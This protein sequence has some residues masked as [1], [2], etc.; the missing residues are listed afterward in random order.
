[1]C[2]NGTF[3]GIVRVA[4]SVGCSALLTAVAT[5][6]QTQSDW[7]KIGSPAVELSL[8]AAATGPVAQVWFSPDGTQLFARTA[9]GRTFIT[10]DFESWSAVSD[11]VPPAPAPAPAV[12]LP[13]PG[14]AVMIALTDPSQLFALGQQLFRSEDG[15]RSWVDL[16]KNRS[17]SVVGTGQHSIAVSPADADQLVLAND[18]GVWRSLDGGLTWA[19]LNQALPNLSIRRILATPN[20]AH[21]VQVEADSLGS[22]ELPPGTSLWLAASNASHTQETALLARYSG[23]IGTAITA[24]AAAGAIV[25]AGSRDGRIWVS[26]DGGATFRISR[27]ETAGPVERFYVDPTEPTLA[28]AALSGSGPHVLRTTTT[29]SLWDDLTGN[30]P[31]APAHGITAERA[32]GAVYVATDQGVFL[33]RTDLQNATVPAANWARISTGLPSAAAWD[34]RLDPAGVQ[35]YAALDGYGVYA[36]A[37][38]HRRW[39]L[40]VVSTADFAP[41]PAAP[42]AL[43]SIVGGRVSGASGGDLN[44]PILSA[45][46]TGSQ[47]QV[48]F[49]AVGPNVALSLETNSGKLTLGLPVQPTAPAIFVGT[50]GVPMIYDADSALPLDTHNPAHSNGRIQILATGL[51][52]VRPDWPTNLPAPAQNPP[53]VI[54]SVQVYLDGSALQVTSATLAPLTIGFYIIEAQLPSITNL[55][56]SELYV[57]ADGQTSNRVQIVIEP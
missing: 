12:N 30:L 16:T 41:H 52:K 36:T 46:D 10:T 54:A 38:P 51:G 29:G 26:L 1:M 22:L 28:L 15:G 34:V 50:D 53:A 18:F 45:S 40:R 4:V 20:G 42:G 57:T 2:H 55:G 49:E 11:A 31:D 37:A 19:G 17:A 48:P 25:Y 39:N 35:L 43:L 8:A 6:A 13:E 3:A 47:I 33:A 44:Y 9:S 21:G 32:A 56:T 14:A 23:T 7:R 24:T 5:S 27:T